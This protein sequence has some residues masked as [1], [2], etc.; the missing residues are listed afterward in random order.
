ML[1]ETFATAVS[2]ALLLIINNKQFSIVE[3]VN[4]RYAEIGGASLYT[5]CLVIITGVFFQGTR[6]FFSG[7]LGKEAEDPI[8]PPHIIRWIV[9]CVFVFIFGV[10]LYLLS[11]YGSSLWSH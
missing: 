8:L 11:H 1:V 10:T 5:I 4:T 3:Y 6:Q 9:I 2:W 7:Y